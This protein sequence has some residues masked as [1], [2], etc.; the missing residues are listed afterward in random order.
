[1]R[2][3]VDTPKGESAEKRSESCW[4]LS[5]DFMESNACPCT[6]LPPTELSSST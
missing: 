4:L 5:V 6:E 2:F 1:M 3:E